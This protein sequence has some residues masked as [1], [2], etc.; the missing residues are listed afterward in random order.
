MSVSSL[1]QNIEQHRAFWADVAKKNGWYKQP[2]YVQVW[3][4]SSDEITDSVSHAGLEEDIVVRE[5]GMA[6]SECGE[7]LNP[8]VDRFMTDTEGAIFCKNCW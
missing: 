4:N 1:S 8:S 2:F 6:C 3:V 5:I 7:S